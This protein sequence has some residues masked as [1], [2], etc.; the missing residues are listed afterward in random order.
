MSELSEL[1]LR[2]DEVRNGADTA[3]PDNLLPVTSSA[4]VAFVGTGTVTIQDSYNVSSITDNG[5]GNYDINFTTALADDDY[6]AVVSGYVASG[7]P[8]FRL[9]SEAT[10]GY[11]ILTFNN[12]TLT[13]ANRV[14]TIAVGGQ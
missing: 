14:N 3:L 13:D 2:V 10:T 7:T 1:K 12:G 6:A 11:K 9:Q 5:S 4:R 8:T